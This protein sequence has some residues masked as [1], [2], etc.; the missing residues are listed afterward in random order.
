LVFEYI[1]PT[2]HLV[3]HTTNIDLPNT[4]MGSDTDDDDEMRSRDSKQREQPLPE[5]DSKRTALREWMKDED[6]TNCCGCEDTFGVF[7]RRHHCR[8]CGRI[9]CDS[10]SKNQ[11]VIPK[12]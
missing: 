7:L 8:H 5:N 9:F 12:V 10:C 3:I 2:F 1:L 6:V 4:P 11:I